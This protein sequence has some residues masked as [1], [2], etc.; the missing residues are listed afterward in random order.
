MKESNRKYIVY[1]HVS[2]SGKVYVRMK[3]PIII[4]KK[5]YWMDSEDYDK[6]KLWRKKMESRFPRR[7]CQL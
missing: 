6:I 1:E 2:P 7:N 3:I 5:E 4:N